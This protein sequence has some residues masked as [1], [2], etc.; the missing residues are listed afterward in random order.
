MFSGRAHLLAEMGC[1]G[2]EEVTKS[3]QKVMNHERQSSTKQDLRDPSCPLRLSDFVQS[4]TKLIARD[5]QSVQI[6][7]GC[8]SNRFCLE[9]FL[10]KVL[11]VLDCDGFDL[12]DQLV[13]ILEVVEVHLLPRQV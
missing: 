9:E 2:R 13:E 5:L 4:A 7:E 12:L 11:Q 6:P 10:S 3:K 1:N 8:D